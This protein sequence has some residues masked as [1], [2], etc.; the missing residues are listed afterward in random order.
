MPYLKEI[1]DIIN[2]EERASTLA[3][4]RFQKASI[5]SIAHLL[6]REDVTIPAIVDNDG[7][8]TDLSIDDV[9]AFM[10]YHRVI[11]L[12]YDKT[13]DFGD[14]QITQETAN[15]IMVV[16]GDRNILQITKEQ[17]VAGVEAG[18]PQE[19]TKAQK[20]LYNLRSCEIKTGDV[21]L[22][23]VLVFRGEY[24]GV[25]YNLKP[26]SILFSIPYTIVSEYDRSCID[27]C[28]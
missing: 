22:D 9:K 13:D 8:C 24:A 16:Y 4:K 18:F 27:I 1:V 10:I 15:M 2:V 3:D 28:T 6:P 17:L 5:N 7:E 26:N 11:D 21:N 14:N 19:L 25:E 23:S 12:K 20:Q